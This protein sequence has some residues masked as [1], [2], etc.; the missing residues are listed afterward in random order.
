MRHLDRST[1]SSQPDATSNPSPHIIYY[2]EYLDTRYIHSLR[3][4]PRQASERHATTIQM[5]AEYQAQRRALDEALAERKKVE[6]GIDTKKDG[7][8][9]PKEAEKLKINMEC[10]VCMSQVVDT[11]LIPCGHAALCRWCADQ[12][13]PPPI[14]S[15]LVERRIQECPVCRKPVEQKLR[16]FIP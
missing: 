5:R 16:I 3:P 6:V 12:Y 10:K 4:P 1:S 11:V 2:P 14:E 9:E 13:F 8:P 7:R 15:I